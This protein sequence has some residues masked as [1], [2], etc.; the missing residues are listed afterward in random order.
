MEE[1]A[2]PTTTVN[3]E[4]AH[5]EID[6]GVLIYRSGTLS[7]TVCAEK[8]GIYDAATGKPAVN[9]PL[10][11]EAVSSV[12][13]VPRSAS[14]Q[15]QVMGDDWFS[16]VVSFFVK[17]GMLDAREEYDISDVMTAL[18]DNYAPAPYWVPIGHISEYGFEKLVTRDHYCVSVSHQAEKEYIIPIYIE[19]SPPPAPQVMGDDA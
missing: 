16:Q 17:H 12:L 13:D 6:D 15:K 11:Y 2:N 19:Y 8:V 10:N 18:A 3:V 7:V 4:G 1:N 9:V 14:P 5:I